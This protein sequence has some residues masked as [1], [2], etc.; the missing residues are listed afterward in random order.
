MQITPY[1]VKHSTCSTRYSRDVIFTKFLLVSFP[2]TGGIFVTMH[3]L[4]LGE[5]KVSEFLLVYVIY[6]SIRHTEGSRKILTPYIYFFVIYR[7]R[8]QNEDRARP[9]MI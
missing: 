7:L 5:N 1:H 3:G 9:G 4:H 6:H 2:I 8:A